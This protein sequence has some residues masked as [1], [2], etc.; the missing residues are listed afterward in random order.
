[1]IELIKIMCVFARKVMYIL[2]K[3]SKIL[4]GWFWLYYG[5]IMDHVFYVF[6]KDMDSIEWYEKIKPCTYFLAWWRHRMETFSAL[7]AFCAG[8][9]T[10]TGEFPAHRP[11]MWS[12]DVF[13]DL[14]LNKQLSKQSWDWWF[15]TLCVHSS[16]V[17]TQHMIKEMLINLQTQRGCG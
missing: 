9:S 7:L 15:E 17:L 4:L 13:F 5:F 16:L 6:L 3:M 2:L 12:F 10:V 8:N 1:M 14:R 11:V